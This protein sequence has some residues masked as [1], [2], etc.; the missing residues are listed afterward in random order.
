M[1]FTRV[2]AHTVVE[3][4]LI[5]TDGA[6]TAFMLIV[7]AFEIALS[8]VA[9]AALEVNRHVITSLLDNDTELNDAELVPTTLP[10]LLH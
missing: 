2:P 6:T 10:F 4:V 9:H 5:A 8:G 1:K 7:T 3:A